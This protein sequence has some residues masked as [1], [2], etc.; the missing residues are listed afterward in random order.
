MKKFENRP[1][2]V[3]NSI[4]KDMNRLNNMV[5]GEKEGERM[6]NISIKSDV[7]L[8]RLLSPMWTTHTMLF[9]GRVAKLKT[10]MEAIR[11]PNYP[12]M[13]LDKEFLSKEDIMSIPQEKVHL[14]NFWAIV[15]SAVVERVRQDKKL[16]DM[17][18]VNNLEFTILRKPKEIEYAGRLIEMSLVDTKMA[19]YVSI[20]RH[21]EL[22]IKE[23]TFGDKN[24]T[25]EFIEKCKSSPEEDLFA[26]IQL[27]I[28]E[29]QKA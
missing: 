21:I 5:F 24:K 23:E 28:R 7:E 16:T 27:P 13:F 25:N 1:K 26:N 10:F 6:V 14:P 4:L 3:D 20:I 29:V 9:C 2:R 17:L 11:T 15:A 12:V 22:M 18:K 19:N 8:G